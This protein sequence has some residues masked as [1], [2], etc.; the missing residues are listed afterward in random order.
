MMVE[1]SRI[2]D[3]YGIGVSIWYPAMDKDYSDPKTGSSR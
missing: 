1:M 3:E 2:A